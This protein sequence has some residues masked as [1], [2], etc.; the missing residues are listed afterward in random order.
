M[1]K[2]TTATSRRS[3]GTLASRADHHDLYQC[4]VQTPDAEIDFV[5]ETFRSI[6]KRTASTLREDFCGTAYTSCE[7]VRR[8]ASNTAIG[9]DLDRPTLDWGIEHNLASL[10]PAARSRLTLLQEDVLKVRTERAV[11]I[12]LAMN[13]SYYIFK[14]RETL[15]RYFANVRT[16]LAKDGVLMLDAFGGSDAFRVLK[17]RRRIPHGPK[18]IGAFTYIWDQASYNPISGDAMCKIHFTLRD[19]SRVRDAFTYDWR[20]WTLPEIREV[21]A[22]AGYARSTVYWEGTDPMTNE[23]DGVF[24]PTEQ[25][26]PDLGWIAYIVA[27]A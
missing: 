1:T 13:F 25:G 4:A 8:R 17:E 9:V 2:R 5:D 3:A 12:V 14:R 24:L 11:D 23:G 6:R 19:G 27:E 20:M 21:L 7:W 10:K 26:T 16:G 22:E 18:G 15:R